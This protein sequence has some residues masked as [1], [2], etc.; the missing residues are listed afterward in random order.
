LK[1]EP[2]YK[3]RYTKQEDRG[4]QILAG[5]I[6][7]KGDAMGAG[8]ENTKRR[9]TREKKKKKPRNPKKRKLVQKR[10]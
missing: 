3:K 10:E 1:A 4:V 7:K 6:E 8:K 9:K 5:K 2:T